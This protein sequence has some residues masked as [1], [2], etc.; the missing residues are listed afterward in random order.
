MS[1]L[2]MPHR[3]SLP[4]KGA[5]IDPAEHL[6]GERLVQFL[7]MPEWVPEPNE[8]TYRRPKSC[9]KVSREHELQIATRLLDSGLG[10]IISD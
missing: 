10:V 1:C 2:T 8:D 9:H 6:R 5:V 3:V 7:T 4:G